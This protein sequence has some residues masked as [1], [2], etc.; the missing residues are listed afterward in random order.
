MAAQINWNYLMDNTLIIYPA[1]AMFLLTAGCLATLGRARFKA[2]RNREVKI[3]YFRT[4]NEGTQPAR[5]HLL[6]RHVQNHFEIPPLFYIAVLFTYVSESVT[7]AAVILAWFYV[8]ARCVHTY[9]HLGSNN[10][11]H[12]F[13][14]FIFSGLCVL[15]LWLILAVQLLT[16]TA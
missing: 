2:I 9:I 11:T 16:A 13:F 1:I 12:R 5:L 4:Y 7:V 15:A 3:S 8:A 14:V 10:V 6:S